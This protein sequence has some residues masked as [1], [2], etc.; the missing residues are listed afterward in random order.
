MWY[1]SIPHTFHPLSRIFSRGDR[2][3]ITLYHLFTKDR[4]VIHLSISRVGFDFFSSSFSFL[5]LTVELLSLRP[6]FV[7]LRDLKWDLSKRYTF[8]YFRHHKFVLFILFFFKLKLMSLLPFP[9]SIN[10]SPSINCWRGS[11]TFEVGLSLF[12]FTLHVLSWLTILVR[13]GGRNSLIPVCTRSRRYF[14]LLICLWGN[15]FKRVV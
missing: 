14:W 13:I 10:F 11:H 3:V 4:L 9:E 8:T 2:Q 7:L 1:H 5:V 12:S 15:T 6:L